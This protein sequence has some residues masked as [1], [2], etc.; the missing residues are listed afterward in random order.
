[1]ADVPSRPLPY[2]SVVESTDVLKGS[3]LCGAIAFEMQVARQFGAG[4]AMGFCPC[5][6]CQRWTG[7]A[8]LPF[9]VTVPERFSTVR[10]QDLMAHY[11]D[12]SSV[13][14]TFCRRCGS[15]LYQDTGTTY[16]VSAGALEGL[17]TVSSLHLLAEHEPASAQ[18]DQQ[19][20]RRKESE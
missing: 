12:D 10:G 4:R 13:I 6:R 18:A 19:R 1:M 11:R 5:S 8:G 2:F 20:Q 7:G 3:C 9:V 15:S 16:Y 14:R 17:Q